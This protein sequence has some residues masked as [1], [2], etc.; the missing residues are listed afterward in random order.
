MGQ[1]QTSR[2]KERERSLK[3]KRRAQLQ[4]SL[5]RQRAADP[6]KFNAT[7]KRW[8]ERNPEKRRAYSA[9][10]NAIRDGKLKKGP[11]EGCG[12]QPSNAVHAHH[13]DYAKP[14]EVR[15][16]CTRC[17]GREHRAKNEAERAA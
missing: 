4:A 12:R 6:E 2:A 3:P 1:P 14:L 11:C 16:L 8:S 5:R 13:D 17:H 7:S 9:V 10:G 15:W